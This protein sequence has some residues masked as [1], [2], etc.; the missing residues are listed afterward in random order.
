MLRHVSG[1]GH[2]SG[3]KKRAFP[4][5][6]RPYDTNPREEIKALL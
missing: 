4:V 2:S 6:K 5:G 1:G 3:K